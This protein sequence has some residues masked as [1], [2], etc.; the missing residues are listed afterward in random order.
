MLGAAVKN[1]ARKP[2]PRADHSSNPGPGSSKNITCIYVFT[3][4][5][6]MAWYNG[7]KECSMILPTG[8]RKSSL[9]Y[10]YTNTCAPQRK[11]SFFM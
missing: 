4:K 1:Y 9:V 11:S 7:E 2:Y 6:L 8:G 3:S 10:N 5:I